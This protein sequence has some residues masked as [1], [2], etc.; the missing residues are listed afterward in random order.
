MSVE[1]SNLQGRYEPSPSDR[2]RQ[3]ANQ[4]HIVVRASAQVI[5]D[6]TSA[7]TMREAAYPPVH[8]IP[9]TDLD[10]TMLRRSTPTASRSS[11]AIT[12]PRR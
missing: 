5:A 2:V 10:Q 6:T 8:Y 11:S 7:L 12:S 9:L 1:T 3:L 4:A